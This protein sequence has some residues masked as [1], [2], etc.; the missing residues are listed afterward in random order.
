MTKLIDE[1]QASE[2]R[3]R[4]LLDE[5]EKA[6]ELPGFEV[7]LTPEEADAL[8]AFEETALKY[9][10]AKAATSEILEVDHDAIAK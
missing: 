5:K 3:F 8:G 7:P 9:A 2:K 4:A 1:S 10:D 6:M